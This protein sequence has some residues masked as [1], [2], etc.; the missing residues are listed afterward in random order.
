MQITGEKRC[1]FIQIISE[2]ISLSHGSLFQASE[3]FKVSYSKQAQGSNTLYKRQSILKNH[4]STSRDQIKNQGTALFPEFINQS[5]A[6]Q[7]NDPLVPPGILTRNR[8]LPY[9]WTNFREKIS[10]R[11]PIIFLYPHST[12][13]LSYKINNIQSSSSWMSVH[14]ACFRCIGVQYSLQSVGY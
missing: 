2:N 1:V 4:N 10:P 13:Q 9:R 12:I 3:H 8:L 5:A 7:S 11:T 6:N 14:V